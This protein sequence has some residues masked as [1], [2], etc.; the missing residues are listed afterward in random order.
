MVSRRLEKGLLL[1]G[2][3]VLAAATVYIIIVWKNIPDSIPVHF[4]ASG[5]ADAFGNRT[6]VL[7]PLVMGW[8]VYGVLAL[9]AA[10]PAVQKSM[11]NTAR[12]LGSVSGMLSAVALS[13]AL[14]FSYICV[15]IANCADLG[16]WFLPVFLV[17][18]LLPIVL[19]SLLA[20]IRR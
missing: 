4:D 12:A 18:M 8:L 10:I 11:G 15:R 16:A 17:L 19:V 7:F 3:L 20:L 6:S 1:A 9:T 2:A 5:R 14:C 13:V